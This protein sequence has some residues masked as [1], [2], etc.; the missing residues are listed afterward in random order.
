MNA[1]ELIAEL[2]RLG[3]ELKVEDEHLRVRAARN[4]ITPE[5]QKHIA[6]RK[7][8]MVALLLRRSADLRSEQEHAPFPLTE[9]QE[10]Y[11]VGRG[12]DFGVGGISCHL[13][14][15][16]DGRELDVARL[17]RAWQRLI[18]QHA[19]LRAV[20]L[21]SGEQRV[22]E[23]VPAFSM[24]VLDLRGQAHDVVEAKLAAIRQELSNRSVPPGQWPSFELRATLLDGNRT[25]IHFDI[26]AI[27]MDAAAVLALL[28]EWRELYVDPERTLEPV[29]VSFRE[30]V[31]AEI[32]ARDT[33]AY[34]SAEAYWR[35]RLDDLPEAPVLPL[36]TPPEQLVRPAF[37][38]LRG[39]LDARRWE[40]LKQRSAEAGLTRSGVVCAAFAEVLAAWSESARFCLNLTLFRRLPI[41]PAIDKVVGDFTTNALLEVDGRGAS[42]THRA[43]QL[44]DQ[45]ARDLEHLHF[46]GVRVMRERARRREG[47]GALMPI[48]FT[49]LLG[50]RPSKAAG[51]SPFGWLGETVHAITQTP[52]VWLDHQ[53]REDDGALCYSWD[54]PEGLFPVG[55]LEDAFAAYEELLGR[56]ADDDASWEE[57]SPVRLPKSQAVRR[58]AFNATASPIPEARLDALFLAQA[59]REPSR[60]AVV[61]PGRTLSY[62]ELRGHAGALASHLV[63][64]GARPDGLIAVV[65]EKGWRQ[66]VAAMA[67]PLA[68]AAYLPIDPTLPE[69]RRRVLLQ[70][71]KVQV[72]VTEPGQVERFAWPEA[73]RVVSIQDSAHGAP[74]SVPSRSASDLA[75]CIYT[76]GS[77]GRPKGVMVEHRAAA[78]TLQDIN[79]RFKVGPEDRVFGLS[80]LGFDLSV[81]DI[82]GS[83]AA[84]AT[85]VLPEPEATWEPT[86]WLRWIR[87][88]RVTV[89]N[90]VP[91]LMEMLVDVVESRGERLPES[92]RLVLLSGDWI[93]VTLPDRIRKLSSEVRVISL[94]G[95]TEGAVWS[96]LHPIARVDPGA[97]SIPYGRPMLNQRFHV[98]DEALAPRPE[99][100]PGD[101]FIGGV[102]L[103]RGYF[104]DE[105]M[106]RARFFTHPGTG[107]RL[108]RTGDLGRF[109]PGGDIEFLGR[110]DFQ[111]KVA[112]HRIEL[113]EIEAALARHP[114]IREAVVAAPGERT[115]RR[116]VGYVVPVEGQPSP[117]DDALREFLGRTLPHY[118]V[119]GVFVRLQA[120]PQSANGKVDRKALPT[121]VEEPSR[122]AGPMDARGG[123]IF[124]QVTQLVAEVLKRPSVEPE[125]S[126]LQLGATSVELIK[127]ATL[128]EKAFGNRPRMSEF[129][130]LRNTAEIVAYYTRRQPA[131]E[132]TGEAV[133]PKAEEGLLLDLE[134]REAWKRAR[135][136]VRT[137]DPGTAVVALA[138]PAEAEARRRHLERAS[139][140]TFS[141]APVEAQALGRLLS[142][143][144]SFD[145]GGRFKYQYGSAG[146]S[147]G[148]QLYLHVAPGRVQGLEAGAYYHEPVR[149]ALVRLTAK[150]A[151]DASLH[152]P[153]NR[154]LFA[155]SAFSLFLVCDRRAIAPLYGE[156]WRDFAL[157]EAGLISQLLEMRAAEQ[158][159]GLCQVGELRFDDVRDA[160]RL[161]E[162]HVYLHG[163]LGGSIAWEEG[164]L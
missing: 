131:E 123:K 41:H 142:C 32:A 54:S 114:A 102:G 17:S 135:H 118:M 46:S 162:P 101:L 83:L 50:H 20:V 14:H 116:L 137:F 66:V 8:E 126:L 108:Y 109:L 136:G 134:Q 73:V 146:N 12:T 65:L 49:S 61:S 93:P 81:Y 115:L 38:R 22:L 125:A 158:Q 156:K 1:T 100:V 133:G 34:R 10:A 36:A 24:P 154:P 82:F 71:G 33:N 117:S 52:Q 75:Y 70:E 47:P 16:L 127:L 111:V 148:V 35:A 110:K 23:Q 9:I 2:T 91:T 79:A 104:G 78:N 157:L 121:P 53:V 164:A 155:S 159:L 42:F 40:R 103:A 144:R 107:E 105:E 132:V 62:E 80:S 3:V 128:L 31:L 18:E 45:L 27:T 139:H 95:A 55:M 56:L 5:L 147:Y 124:T 152:V 99:H 72:V 153:T 85:L 68:G 25:R 21:A 67:I 69:E 143:L 130:T 37:R 112:G 160:F 7:A 122:G 163:L 63:E 39:S 98:L 57:R 76:S 13:Y 94:G 92:L 77:T 119:P 26:D 44:R 86:S 29:P 43:V 141:S 48:V 87:E 90:S 64:L 151:L 88:A 96:I 97:R 138:E 74:P 84:G 140:R 11:L 149:H 150:G 89:W 161:E 4:V 30:H 6:A 28:E 19:M 51:G 145:I 59:Q 113:G 129:L 120:L 58:E 60:L 106:T 15:E